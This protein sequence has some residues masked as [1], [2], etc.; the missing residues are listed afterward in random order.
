MVPPML[1][2]LAVTLL[3]LVPLSLPALLLRLVQVLLM[4][5]LTTLAMS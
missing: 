2:L 1:T 5:L 3:L 4:P